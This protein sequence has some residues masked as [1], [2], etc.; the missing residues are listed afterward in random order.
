VADLRHLILVLRDHL[1]MHAAALDGLDAR[2]DA[3]GMA[4]V[5]EESTSMR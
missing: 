1:D 2:Q 3:V 5:V 4:A